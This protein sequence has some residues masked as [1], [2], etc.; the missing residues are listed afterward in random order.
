MD[1][2]TAWRAA[3]EREL[4][5]KPIDSLGT[6]RD[7][8]V[9]VPPLVEP[10]PASPALP[11]RHG[12]PV[13]GA[14]LGDAEPAPEGPALAWWIGA[15]GPIAAST[16]S[17]VAETDVE[18]GAIGPELDVIVVGARKTAGVRLA[19]RAALDAAEAGGGVVVEL[20]AALAALGAALDAGAMPSELAVALTVGTEFFVEVAKLRAARRAIGGMLSA[21]GHAERAL[22]LVVRQTLRSVAAIDVETN[23]LR[24]TLAASAA[25]VGGA[26]HVALQPHDAALRPA[27][28][29]AVA[30][31]TAL[32]LAWAQGEVL[33]RESHLHLADDAASGAPLV[34][35]LTDQIGEAAWSLARRALAGDGG[36]LAERVPRD[37]E[38]RRHAIA[39]RK[40]PLV[41]VTRFVGAAHRGTSDAR[42]AA[43]FEQ[44][45]LAGA[46]RTAVVVAV[47]D[48]KLEPRADFA[49][50]VAELSGCEVG[51]VRRGTDVATTLAA[52]P[53]GIALAIVAVSDA[54]LAT[55]A[56]ALTAA[57]TARGA[58]VLVAARPGEHEASL[59]QAGARGFVFT[60]ADVLHVLSSALTE[61]AS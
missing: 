41:G 40:R 42:D 31:P 20:A 53:A 7:D 18:G 58:T 14:V 45:R 60:G 10:R 47:G 27:A 59:R 49:Q 26:T 6:T 16:R 33:T 32:R 5:G 19:S 46:G 24:G 2:Y 34:E 35:S 55:D 39:T 3:V 36:A 29:S 8:G 21:A 61:V 57:L 1:S 54:A 43:P 22:P 11:R 9:R 52:V 28:L 13:T 25:L 15:P 51:A 37:A 23:A 38:A 12:A 56:V 30:D 17:V 50:Q 44:L 48:R 4:A